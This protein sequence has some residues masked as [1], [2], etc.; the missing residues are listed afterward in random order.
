MFFR[1]QRRRQL[2][3]I[4][5]LRSRLG[6]PPC[7]GEHDAIHVFLTERVYDAIGQGDIQT[8]GLDEVVI[9]ASM[10]DQCKPS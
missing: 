4:A 10:V 2:D 1:T 6:L 3:H 8:L 5:E 7:T 9:V